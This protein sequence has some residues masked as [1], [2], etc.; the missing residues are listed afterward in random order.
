M[1]WA[2]SLPS[3]RKRTICSGCNS[4]R[5]QC[6][7]V[8]TSPGQTAGIMLAPVTLR[9]TSPALEATSW[10]S[11]QQTAWRWASGFMR[12]SSGCLAVEVARSLGCLHLAASQSHGFE[13]VLMPHFRLLVR[14]LCGGLGL[15]RRRNTGVLFRMAHHDL[16][17]PC[18]GSA[19]EGQTGG[20][21]AASSAGNF[22]NARGFLWIV[23]RRLNTGKCGRSASRAVSACR[24]ARPTGRCTVQIDEVNL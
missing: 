8:I 6:R 5:S 10:T 17:L 19:L 18:L 2:V 13:H 4:A 14:L 15:C 20:W 23:L 7:T 16:I 21:M 3:R 1:R 11:S 12:L 9:R 22:L 24:S